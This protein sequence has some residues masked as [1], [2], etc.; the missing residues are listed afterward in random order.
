[1]GQ[2]VSSMDD[3]IMPIVVL[4]ECSKEEATVDWGLLVRTTKKDDCY[5]YK[6]QEKHLYYTTDIILFKFHLF[7]LHKF[8]RVQRDHN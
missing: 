4:A 7:N 8:V 6:E 3:I 2:R 5:N 1:M